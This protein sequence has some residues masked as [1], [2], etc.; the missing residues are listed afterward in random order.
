MT[1]HAPRPPVY[2]HFLDTQQYSSTGI[3]RY[4]RVYGDGFVC[5][6]GADTTRQLVARLELQP[7]QRVLDI[8]CGIGGEALRWRRVLLCCA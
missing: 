2:R 5:S 3:L 1:A 7:G 8:G 4:E 6:G